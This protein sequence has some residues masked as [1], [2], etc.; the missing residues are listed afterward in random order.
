[1]SATARFADFVTGARAVRAL[2]Q[3]GLY[4]SNCRLIDANEAAGTGAGDGSA[5]LL[6]LGFESADH[7]LEAW[8]AR[9]TELVRDHGGTIDQPKEK[10]PSGHREGAAGAWR[11]AFLRA[12]FYREALVPLGLIIDT[13]ETAVTWDKFPAF[14][15][16]ITSRMQ[17]VL[18]RVTGRPGSVTCR[19]THVYPDGPAPYFTFQALGRFDALM[20]QWRTIKEAANEMVVA[21][22]GTIT[23]HHAVGRDHR[24]GYVRECPPLFADALRAAKRSLDPHGL[25]NPGVLIDPA[26]RNVGIRGAMRE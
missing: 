10:S 4:P 14:H 13:F 5:A 20:D 16:T 26:G 15:A 2:G 21:A 19:F 7:P 12:P 9:A 25:L 17:D 18:A 24:S 11:N 23:H 6:V 3:S 8:A 22:G 1:M